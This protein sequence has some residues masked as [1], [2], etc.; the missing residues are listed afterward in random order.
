MSH[1]DEATL[2]AYHDGELPAVEA[3][4]IRR[5]VER[6]GECRAR[7]CLRSV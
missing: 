1:H 2:V 6:C 4:S 5:H 3:E 7:L